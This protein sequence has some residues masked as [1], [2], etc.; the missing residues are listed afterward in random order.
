MQERANKRR[1][2]TSWAQRN[3]SSSSGGS[4]SWTVISA[5]VVI[6]LVVLAGARKLLD[7]KDDLPFP[8]TAEVSWYVAP[9]QGP[10]APL[11]LH[12]PKDTEAQFVVLLDDWATKQPVAMIPLRA[13]ETARLH[14][15]FGRYR[16]VM[17]KGQGWQGSSK[18][19]RRVISSREAVYPLDFTRVGNRSS[20]HII[21]LETVS[22]NLE[23][24]P[25]T[26]R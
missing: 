25:S 4:P 7:P 11:T 19:F 22:G 13:R 6:F 20:G 21:E 26:R 9:A 1:A 24:R 10:T 2:S 15:P 23:T 5:W 17:I 14:V 18:L 8:A 16:L 12:A 3:G